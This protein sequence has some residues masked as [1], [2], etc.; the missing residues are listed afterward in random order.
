MLTLRDYPIR[1]KLIA[2]ILF[3]ST[4][5]L[6]LMCAAFLVSDFFTLRNDLVRT[7]SAQEEMI[8]LNVTSA[9]LFN[10]STSAESTL[11]A[12]R[13]E[14]QVSAAAVYR[15]DGSVLA[16]YKSPSDSSRQV[17]RHGPSDFSPGAEFSKGELI[18]VRHI[19]SE[20]ENIGT[21]VVE[22]NLSDMYGRFRQNGITAFLVL[23]AALC[24]AFG[25]SS[26]LHRVLSAPIQQLTDLASRISLQKDYSARLL[27]ERKD[28]LGQLANTFN[29]M[30]DRIVADINA[31]ESAEAEV[32]TLNDQ[33]ED[34]VAKRTA[35]LAAANNRL[36]DF[37]KRIEQQNREL[38]V[39]RRE[40]E[41]ATQLKSAFLASMSHELRTPLNAILGFSELM[42]DQGG[43]VLNEKQHR[44]LNHIRAAGKHLLQLI[45]DIL[46]LSKIESGQ[47]SLSQEDFELRDA[48][49]EVL[50]IVKP[51]AMAKRIQLRS[52]IEPSAWVH[53]DRMRFKQVA[54]NLLSNAVKFTPEEGTVSLECSGDS[55]FVTVS[56]TDTGIGILADDQKVVFEEFRQ[57][58]ETTRGTK[59]GTGLGLAIAKRLIEQQG[60]RIWLESE[61]GR[62]SRFAFTLPVALSRISAKSI[63]KA[64]E[65]SREHSIQKPRVLVVDDEAPALELMRDY[66]SSDGFEVITASSGEE[67][68]QKAKEL[69]PH[70]ITLDVM[71]PGEG[72][73]QVLHSLRNAPETSEIPI[74]VVSILDR[75]ESGLTLGASDY[76]VKPVP[77]D[78]LLKTV[79][80]ALSQSAQEASGTVLVVDDDPADRNVIQEIIASAGY[81][82]LVAEDGLAAMEM[83]QHARPDAVLLDLVMPGLD[84]FQVLGRMKQDQTLRHI[85]VF[86][87]SA[88]E[89]TKDE[90]GLLKRDAQAYFQK[91]DHWKKE[92][93]NRVRQIA[94]VD[95]G[96][97]AA[98]V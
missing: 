24:V 73:W 9:V 42:Q 2:G 80:K 16:T 27:I 58:G 28:E 64:V 67:A 97:R 13:A 6:V 84:G 70:V 87:L 48:L 19:I 83:L 79:R 44:W 8:A 88:K 39:R 49:P 30:L 33:L 95:C 93:L 66:L 38:E 92:L 59:E 25:I 4:T 7:F 22:V 53:A 54:F 32:R 86:I 11:K 51:L 82:T 29:E 94:S 75:K 76:L 23:V 71:M 72:G 69:H 1:K 34:R 91:G 56:V 26:Q 3:A 18:L 15:K 43:E 31:R 20:G 50:S 81:S 77:K 96:I 37:A 46:D 35:E 47:L 52:N 60:G 85:P 12:L 36:E 98:A 61:I 10:D 17:G 21:L 63:V 74:I 40:A 89:L 68:V 45:N 90:V 55:E 41:R 78:V 57:V 5:V 14:P 62:G 65:S